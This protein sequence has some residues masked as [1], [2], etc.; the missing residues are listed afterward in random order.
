MGCRPQDGGNTNWSLTELSGGISC[1]LKNL[2]SS[3]ERV[4]N[5]EL[6]SVLLA[7]KDDSM[8]CCSNLDDTNN[9][10]E[11]KGLVS[12][13]AYAVLR[14]ERMTLRTGEELTMVKLRNPW[15]STEWAGKW[16]DKDKDSWRKVRKRE[17]KRIGFENKD[18]GSFWMTFEDWVKE[19]EI[20]NFCALPE[21]DSNRDDG[22]KSNKKDSFISGYFNPGSSSPAIPSQL[23]K[24]FLES[25]FNAQ[26]YFEVTENLIEEKKQ[27]Q[28]VWLQLLLDSKITEKT[29]VIIDLYRISVK[30]KRK[31]EKEELKKARGSKVLPLIPFSRGYEIEIYKHN[32][33]LFDLKPG[34]YLIVSRKVKYQF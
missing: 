11:I 31:L 5:I 3:L 33:Y 10:D 1:E 26:A 12:L 28:L 14:V 30:P 21:L 22:P 18:D 9:S 20:F 16:A 4:R 29:Q 25:K 2:A 32:G 27:T 6:E 13:H 19:F 15:G 23:S 24:T 7:I 17:K 34:K 8:I